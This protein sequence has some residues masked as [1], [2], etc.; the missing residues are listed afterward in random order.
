MAR[1]AAEHDELAV[2][3]RG[4]EQSRTIT[5]DSE[6]LTIMIRID[7][8]KDGTVRVDGWLAPSQR[9]EVEM[10]CAAEPLRVTTD[11]QGRFRLLPGTAR[12]GAARGQAG[13]AGPSRAFRGPPPRSSSEI[14]Y[15]TALGDVAGCPP[16][17][18]WPAG[19]AGPARRASAPCGRATRAVPRRASA[20]PGPCL[21]HLGWNEDG[22]QPDARQV[23]EAHRPLAARL[24]GMIGMWEAEL[25]RTGYGLSLLGRAEQLAPADERGVLLGQQGTVYLHT[26]REQD[27]V[28]VLGE[29]V[30]ELTGRPAETVNLARTLL[31]R[32]FAC[33][34]LVQVNR[35]RADLDWCR[36]IATDEGHDLLSAKALHNLGYCD[37]LAG[38]IPAALRLFDAAAG[39]FRLSTPG[40]L[41]LLA[42]DKA[43]ALLAAG[44]ASDAAREL[45]E[46][47]TWSGGQRPG[48]DLARAQ[49]VRAQA[50][51][52]AGELAAARQAGRRP[53]GGA[54]GSGATTPGPV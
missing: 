38:D 9:R 5:F 19:R 7:A 49:L 22:E 34:G 35:A 31:N 11:E 50:A 23:A 42:T 51:L 33:L 8:N 21:R 24:L 12:H 18:R 28:A 16:P 27:A 6:T 40:F 48:P 44:L 20:T 54:S 52:A 10:K 36:R 14:T 30:A 17:M 15:L 39:A 26:G 29:A 37:L 4:T 3:A 46:A 1:L 47:M 43:S 25:G 41:L 32:S 53:P 2:A 45:D 13:R